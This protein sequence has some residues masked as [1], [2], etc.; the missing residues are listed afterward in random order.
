MIERVLSH[1]PSLTGKAQAVGLDDLKGHATQVPHPVISSEVRGL[2]VWKQVES[3]RKGLSPGI[4][5][6][7]WGKVPR[8]EFEGL[9]PLGLTDRRR[10]HRHVGL[11]V[12]SS[13]RHMVHFTILLPLVVGTLHEAELGEQ[14][15]TKLRG[16]HRADSRKQNVMEHKK[17]AP[18]ASCL[19]FPKERQRTKSS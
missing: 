6:I 7:G 15:G 9:E 2:A 14:A 13:C 1:L 4:E 10:K 11:T 19:K 17:V 3:R 8:R 12:R 5:P 16:R 18:S